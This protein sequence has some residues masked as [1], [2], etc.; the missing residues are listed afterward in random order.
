VYGVFCKTSPLSHL[1]FNFP[2]KD[3][4]LSRPLTQLDYRERKGPADAPSFALNVTIS[5]DCWIGG[6]VTVLG[7][8]TI[9][10]GCVIGA[11]STVTRVSKRYRLHPLHHVDSV[12]KP[13]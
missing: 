7:G 1:F 9:G 12:T 8:V 6:R 10:K 4:G 3:R 11:G 5:D 2:F 13:L